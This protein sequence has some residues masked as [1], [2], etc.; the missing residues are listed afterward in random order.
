MLLTIR[1]F[2]CRFKTNFTRKH[3]VEIKASKDIYF[4][5]KTR[6]IKRDCLNNPVI[7][8]SSKK[9][10]ING[11]SGKRF[12][13]RLRDKT[14]TCQ[15]WFKKRVLLLHQ[16]SWN[17]N[18]L[19][20]TFLSHLF[21][22]VCCFLI[23]ECSIKGSFILTWEAS[24][25]EFSI[26]SNLK[27]YWNQKPTSCWS[28]PLGRPTVTALSDHCF[29][30]CCPSVRPS[31][32]TFQNLAKQNKFQAKTMFTTCETVGLAEWIIDDTCLVRLLH[33]LTI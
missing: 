18:F 9:Y 7:L 28:N 8:D 33:S 27:I 1:N 26:L 14:I 2:N 25:V 21:F 15:R 32:P 5:T 11:K 16:L 31:V 19:L 24:K 20:I 3:R 12:N 10:R 17:N 29:H 13:C 30:T 6:K 4:L 23:S 22:Q